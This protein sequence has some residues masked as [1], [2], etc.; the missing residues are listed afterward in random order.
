MKT[1]LFIIVSLWTCT[2]WAGCPDEKKT[3]LRKVLTNLEGIETAVYNEQIKSWMPGDTLYREYF[4]L[5]KE[6]DN[7]ADSTIGASFVWWDAS[8]TTLVQS[9]YDGTLYAS[10][11]HKENGVV[12]DDFTT[13]NLP[14]R[15]ISPPFF[16]YAKS[17][18]RYILNTTDSISVV[19]QESADDYHF[20]LTIYED[21]QIEFFGAPFR[22][23]KNPYIFDEPT[24]IYELS[25]RKSDYLPYK[26]RREM[27]HYTTESTY[28]NVEINRSQTKSISVYDFIPQNYIIKKRGEKRNDHPAPSLLDQQAPGW[29]L[30][31]TSGQTISLSDLKSKVIVMNFTGIGCGPCIMSIPFL[32]SI[33]ELFA[34]DD[35]EVISVECW[36]NKMHS[37]CV[38]KDKNKINYKFVEGNDTIIEQY[39]N[40]NRGVPVFF[41]LDEKRIIK[42]V[43]N[44]YNPETTGKELIE[45][46]KAMLSS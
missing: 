30:N 25:F 35:C 26:I 18:I 16:N 22:M 46:I 31:E 15:P 17:I 23:P 12:I 40:G 36:K 32:N 42:K 33:K 28:A 14:M 20:K 3:I 13:R 19:C 6:Y 21:Q 11:Y 43:V 2:A 44:G 37:L 45:I 9:C 7:P 29:T 1:L 39:L 27:S 4:R 24:S 38:Y 8:D 10:F 34:V 41:I 5:V